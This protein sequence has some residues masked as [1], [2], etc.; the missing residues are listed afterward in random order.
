M[1][2]CDPWRR[3]APRSHC[4]GQRRSNALNNSVAGERNKTNQ[5][6]HD[7]SR[8]FI[9]TES[10]FEENLHFFRCG[11][12]SKDILPHSTDATREPAGETCQVQVEREANGATVVVEEELPFSVLLSEFTTRIFFDHLVGVPQQRCITGLDSGGAGNWLLRQGG[13]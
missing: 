9:Q 5:S 3:R 13:N 12:R 7:I 4:E 2:Q 8:Y 10:R 1:Q 11:D 6:C